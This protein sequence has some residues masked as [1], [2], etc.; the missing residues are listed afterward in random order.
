MSKTGYTEMG[1]SSLG[2]QIAVLTGKKYSTL[3]IFEGGIKVIYHENAC[4]NMSPCCGWTIG[5]EVIPKQSI[6]NVQVEAHSQC[7]CMPLCCLDCCH[8]KTSWVVFEILTKGNKPNRMK[9]VLF[10]WTKDELKDKA[11]T[12][13]N[14]VYGSVAGGGIVNDAHNLAHFVNQGIVIPS[15]APLKLGM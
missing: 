7:C 3:E 8:M 9:A 4:C 12:L 5:Y 2:K 15:A 14:Y 10:A 6:V 13:H 1:G 11:E